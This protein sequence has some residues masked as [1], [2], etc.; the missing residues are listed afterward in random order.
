MATFVTP[1]IFKCVDPSTI[2]TSFISVVM[3]L[4]LLL[5]GWA[6]FFMQ[7]EISGIGDFILFL[8]QVSAIVI[9]AKIGKF[10]HVISDE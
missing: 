2:S 6:L 9:G 1:Q 10:M 8:A 7:K 5:G 4:G 3:T